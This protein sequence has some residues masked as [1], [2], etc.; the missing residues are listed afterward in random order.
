[1]EK[2]YEKIGTKNV[3]LFIKYIRNGLVKEDE[4]KMIALK[5]DMK[6]HG[7]YEE[8]VKKKCPEDVIHSMLDCW[9]KTHLH[10][11]D[12]DGWKALQSVLEDDSVKRNHIVQEINDEQGEL[13]SPLKQGLH[14]NSEAATTNNE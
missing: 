10:K 7:V 1:M 14:Q 5:M 8:I 11:P 13:R 2:V 12:V 3:D 9:Y 6:V 4:L